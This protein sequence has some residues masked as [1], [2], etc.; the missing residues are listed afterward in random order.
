MILDGKDEGIVQ[1]FFVENISAAVD[2]LKDSEG[3]EKSAS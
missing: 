3:V 1:E 2:R